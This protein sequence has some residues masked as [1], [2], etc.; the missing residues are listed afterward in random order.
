[1]EIVRK[2]KEVGAKATFVRF[3]DRSSA[4]IFS[5]AMRKLYP[6]AEVATQGREPV[7]VIVYHDHSDKIT[8]V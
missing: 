8:D 1:M 6:T 5:N 2:G 3:W 4:T 7:Y